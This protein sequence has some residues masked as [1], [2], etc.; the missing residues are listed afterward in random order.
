MRVKCSCREVLS[1][2][3]HTTKEVIL[4]AKRGKELE[5]QAGAE[6]ASSKFAMHEKE[7]SR[8]DRKKRKAKKGEW[9]R[10]QESL[11]SLSLPRYG[12]LRR[13]WSKTSLSQSMPS[14]H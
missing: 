11:S 2:S 12:G 7:R 8:S 5:E 4:A 6:V 10:A 9:K 14:D 13:N 1:A 3:C